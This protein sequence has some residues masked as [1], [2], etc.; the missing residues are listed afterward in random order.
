LF[1]T[2]VRLI[3]SPVHT[4]P[5]LAAAIGCLVSG[6][7]T[8]NGISE[9]FP[10]FGYSVLAALGLAAIIQLGM[11]SSTLSLRDKKQ[12]QPMVIAV[13]AFTVVMSSFTS[14]VFYFRGFSEETIA[15]ERRLERYESLR[16]YLVDV[17]GQTSGVLGTIREA[18][19]E[20]DQRIEM[21]AASG[22]GLRNISNPY[23]QQLIAESDLI[24]DLRRVQ[25][26]SGERFRFLSSL[27]PR[28]DRMELDV[29]SA[30]EGIDAELAVLTGSDQ[31]DHEAMRASYSRASAI[32]PI[33]RIREVRGEFVAT[34]VDPAILDTSALEEEEY[35]QRAV[36]ELFAG[37]PTA[38]VFAFIAMFIDTMIVFF[39]FV[40]GQGQ[41]STTAPRVPLAHWVRMAYEQRFDEGVRSWIAALD[42][43]RVQRSRD[44]LHRLEVRRLNDDRAAQCA[45]LLRQDGYLRQVML[46]DGQTYWCLTDEAYTALVEL[47]R[48]TMAETLPTPAV[49]AEVFGA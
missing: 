3:K 43:V 7:S 6:Y 15:K 10:N 26:G 4:F 11:L 1:R 45:R 36:T 31:V 25:S 16:G 35:W 34:A 23:L 13:I 41:T 17:R 19:A 33:D 37:S 14:Y 24:V 40:A 22:G 46:E 28:L 48:A 5:A 49:E 38:I 2:L 39:A 42:G 8:F 9:I 12:H 47:S 30:L 29:A 21:E 27:A 18:G 32:V 44:V 20:L